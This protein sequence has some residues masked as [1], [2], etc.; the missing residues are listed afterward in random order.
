[1]R[2]SIIAFYLTFLRLFYL[3]W[4]SF[5]TVMSEV[6]IYVLRTGFHSKIIQDSNYTTRFQRNFLFFLIF[7]KFSFVSLLK[8]FK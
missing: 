4:L 3:P 5:G 8:W 1:M 6:K 7:E 2:L